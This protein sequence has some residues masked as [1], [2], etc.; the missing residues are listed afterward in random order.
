MIGIDGG[1]MTAY[2]DQAV[3]REMYPDLDAVT[4]ITFFPPGKA[5]KTKDGF[6]ASGRWQFGSGCQHSTWMIG[7][8]ATFDGDSPRL[9]RNGLPERTL[10]INDMLPNL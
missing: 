5:V 3:A 2:I 7:H 4:A 8:F 6:M 9:Q 10:P 1:Y